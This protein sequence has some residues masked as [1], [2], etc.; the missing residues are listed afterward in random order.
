MAYNKNKRDSGRRRGFGGRNFR[1]RDSDDFDDED[2][3]RNRRSGVRRSG[4]G[5]NR[6]GFNRKF[7]GR[8]SG[9]RL[10]MVKVTCDECGKKCEVP[11]K[12][13][14]G[15][16]VYCSECFEKKGGKSSSRNKGDSS[17]LSA[18]Q[19]NILNAKLDKIM[20]A[21]NIHNISKEDSEEKSEEFDED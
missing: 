7:G 17:G 20:H 4:G 14:E 5:G 6:G 10:D 12:P 13:T 21:L 9:R 11:F 18:N 16:P 2:S 1:D 3:G 15:K 19:Y 8:D